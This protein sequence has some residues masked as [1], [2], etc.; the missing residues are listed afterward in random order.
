L[1]GLVGAPSSAGAYAPG[2]ERAPQAL[3]DLGLVQRLQET[4]IRVTDYGDVPGFRWRPDR[5]Q[6]HAQNLEAVVSVARSVAENV[7]ALIAAAE[8]PLVLGGDCTVGVGTVAGAVVAGGQ[9][10]G[11]LYFDLH[12]DLN[13]PG[14]VADGALDWMGVAHMLGEPGCEP[15]LAS[16]AGR[17]PMLAADQLLFLGFR[18]DQSTASEREAID[19][20]HLDVIGFEQVFFEPAASAQQALHRL[21][22][23]C[24]RL[25]VHFDVDVIDFTDAPLSE[26]T[27]RNVGLPLAK[28]FE[29]LH[30]LLADEHVVGLTVTEVN[31]D[32]GE[33]ESA[34]LRAFVDRLVPALSAL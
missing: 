30:V 7:A 19:R 15:A 27:G 8:K 33:P 29:V 10:P 6:P 16:L 12:A 23:R 21:S 2:Q 9:R 14:S 28:A 20:H 17:S 3:R 13:V 1:I 24:D 22:S 31:P 11:L 4:G 26:N 18:A 5:H 34:T 32:H 25:L